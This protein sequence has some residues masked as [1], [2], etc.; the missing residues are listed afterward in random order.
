MRG[1]G[2]LYI[3]VYIAKSFMIA[4]TSPRRYRI[5]MNNNNTHEVSLRDGL[6][7]RCGGSSPPP[8]PPLFQPHYTLDGAT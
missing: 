5:L 2:E 7:A 8:P 4:S 6:R 1:R 3:I